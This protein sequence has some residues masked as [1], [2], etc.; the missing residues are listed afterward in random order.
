MKRILKCNTGL[1]DCIE[2]SRNRG[3]EMAWMKRL[4]VTIWYKRLTRSNPRKGATKRKVENFVI[5][6]VLRVIFFH[7]LYTIKNAIMLQSAL[8]ISTLIVLFS[9]SM[10]MFLI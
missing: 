9:A 2:A 5:V 3:A 1:A 6:F 7:K 4:I 10:L 8:M